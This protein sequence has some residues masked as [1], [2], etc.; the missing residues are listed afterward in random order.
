MAIIPVLHINPESYHAV[1]AIALHVC[2][3]HDVFPFDT[4][5][6]N[7]RMIRSHVIV[8]TVQAQ[9]PVQI[10]DIGPK[11]GP[12]EK[13]K[14]K[15]EEAQKERERRSREEAKSKWDPRRSCHPCDSPF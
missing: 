2:D 1:L 8:N 12:K 6:H 11:S 10:P 4:L 14:P 9:M 3:D 7:I 13:S 15:E 5:L